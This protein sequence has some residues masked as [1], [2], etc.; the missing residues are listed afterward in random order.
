MQDIIERLRQHEPFFD[1]W[2]L[3]DEKPLGEGN[4][5][6]VYCIND[7]SVDA[8]LKVIALPKDEEQ[9]KRL[10]ETYGNAEYVE[11]MID[12]EYQF[13]VQEI[14]IMRKLKGL[15]NIVCF[16]DS[17]IY[18]REDVHGWDIIIRMERLI[19]LT[20]EHK[21]S[22]KRDQILKMWTDLVT[23]LF[24][25][26]RSGI[27]HL[28]IKPD[29][30]FY[31]GASMNL[32]K[33]GD[34]GVSIRTEN[35]KVKE[36]IMQGSPAYMS[37]EI[38]NG[39][40]GDIRSDIYS[41]AIVIY[42]LLNN[43][44]LPFM[45]RG[46]QS[47]GLDAAIRRRCTPGQEIP[48]IKSLDSG[49][50][51]ILMRCLKYNPSDRYQTVGDLHKDLQQYMVG[52]KPKR[53][54]LLKLLLGIGAG[55]VAG[56]VLFL[57]MQPAS[58][59]PLSFEGS[60]SMVD[61]G[62]RTIRINGQ[63]EM[64]F[65]L[66]I[67]GSAKTQVVFRIVDRASGSVRVERPYT[68]D[69]NG[70][71]TVWS[72]DQ[73]SLEDG[74]YG[75][76]AWYAD[77]TDNQET[78][79]AIVDRV[80]PSAPT[81]VNDLPYAGA[82]NW[83]LTVSA[84]SGATVCLLVNGAEVEAHTVDE[85]GVTV[86]TR[87]YTSEEEYA[88]VTR[89]AVG[90]ESEAVSFSTVQ[91]DVF[92]GISQIDED[93]DELILQAEAGA[94][95]ALSVNGEPIDVRQ[96]RYAGGTEYVYQPEFGFAAGDA[97]V[98]TVTDA[99]GLQ[100]QAEC[101][102]AE[103]SRTKITVEVSNLDDQGRATD[104]DLELHGTA[105]SG[106]VVQLTW[107]GRRVG[108]EI[109]LMEEEF[110][111]YLSMEDVGVTSDGAMGEVAVVYRHGAASR[112]SDPI[113]VNW[114]PGAEERPATVDYRAVDI[115]VIPEIETNEDN[116]W[117]ITGQT[118]REAEINLF[119]GTRSE[120]MEY[121][122]TRDGEQV[123]AGV[124]TLSSTAGAATLDTDLTGL[125]DGQYRL[126][127]TYQNSPQTGEWHQSFIV[128]RTPPELALDGETPY[129]NVYWTMDVALEPGARLT[130]RD[131]D[132]AEVWSET[133]GEEGGVTLR[134]TFE[135]DVNYSLTA[136]DPYGNTSVP[137]RIRAEEK[138][139]L[140]SLQDIREDSEA[141][142]MT[143]DPDVETFVI[144]LNGETLDLESMTM[145]EQDA[146]GTTYSWQPPSG[147]FE[148]GDT[149]TL[150][151]RDK[152]GL[153]AFDEKAVQE[154]NWAQ[155]A[156]TVD[157]VFEADNAVYAR[158]MQLSLS[159]Q[160]DATVE[161]MW[162]G[163]VIGEPILSEG[164]AQ[165][166]L[167]LEDVGLP[168][169]GGTG[170]LSAR[171]GSGYAESRAFK[172][173]EVTWTPDDSVKLHVEPVREDSEVMSI[174]TDADAT[175]EITRIV[176]G[177]RMEP[178]VLETEDG[179]EEWSPESGRFF[180]DE[181]YEVRVV[182]HIGNEQ[183]VRLVVTESTRRPVTL[184]VD[185]R[186]DWAANGVEPYY[187]DVE[188]VIEPTIIVTGSGEPGQRLNL[189]WKDGLVA[190]CLVSADGSYSGAIQAQDLV[191]GEGTLRVEYADGRTPSL[192]QTVDVMWTPDDGVALNDEDDALQL[193]WGG[194]MTV[195]TDPDARV[196]IEME[197]VA[198]DLGH[199]DADGTLVWT[200]EINY[201]IGTSYVVRVTDIFGHTRQSD[202]MQ[203]EEIKRRE[204]QASIDNLIESS[205]GAPGVTDTT[206]A[207]SGTAEPD[208]MLS[209]DI[210]G[211]AFEAK[212][213][214]AGTF[215][216]SIPSA[217]D[218]LSGDEVNLTIAYADGASASNTVRISPFTWD[219]SVA[220][221]HNLPVTE[222][223]QSLVV[224]AAEPVTAELYYRAANGGDWIMVGTL[225]AGEPQDLSWPLNDGSYPWTRG[226][227]GMLKIVDRWGNSDS[228]TFTVGKTA[229][230]EIR[231]EI[232][233]EAGR[234]L[235]G[236]PVV[237]AD[238][239]TVS[240]VGEPGQTVEAM[241]Y[242][243]AGLLATKETTVNE[244]SEYSVPFTAEELGNRYDDKAQYRVVVGYPW[245]KT[246]VNVVTSEVCWDYVGPDVRIA[247][248][249]A[250]DVSWRTIQ[251]STEQGARVAIAIG[252]ATLEVVATDGTFEFKR[253][254]LLK[255][256]DDIVGKTMTVVAYDEAGNPG[257]PWSITF[258]QIGYPGALTIV[259]QKE[260]GS[261]SGKLRIEGWFAGFDKLDAQILLVSGSGKQLG[262]VRPSY[263]DMT[264]EEKTQNLGDRAAGYGQ[265]CYAFDAEYDLT[266]IPAG[267][268]KLVLMHSDFITEE[269]VS[270]VLFD[271]VKNSAESNTLVVEE[272]VAMNVD[273]VAR[274]WPADGIVMTGWICQSADAA[275][276]STISSVR[277]DSLSGA[278]DSV[279]IFFEFE[280]DTSDN[281][282]AVLSKRS[283]AFVDRDISTL[284]PGILP[285]VKSLSAPTNRKA[286]FILNLGA[287][288]QPLPDG[289]YN[290]TI[291]AY[292]GED[293]KP[294]MIG[295]IRLTIDGSAPRMSASELDA[296]MTEWKPIEVVEPQEGENAE[297]E[298]LTEN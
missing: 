114:Q 179:D 227:R 286:G 69:E 272:D 238:T 99:Y 88:L 96:L 145:L 253:N 249:A 92:A 296:L 242:S 183:N 117:L 174:E 251:G 112:A 124:I 1:I 133:A 83:P 57:L 193:Y 265:Y 154:A 105:E 128:D 248:E 290:L 72:T 297:G 78:Y 158:E 51:R 101:V 257:V 58:R 15:S 64:P 175:I 150:E 113:R 41:L 263:R 233:T 200:P 4:S 136:T 70:E 163:A 36:G 140:A 229:L 48:P 186:F 282:Q 288:E 245:E 266:N 59:G 218:V 139:V 202:R 143:V 226:D 260:N 53:G 170:T 27:V 177:T 215:I 125:E 49:L 228:Q 210:N 3:K 90:N 181:I 28:D 207:L 281:P 14:E 280:N 33:L 118:D 9:L 35:G 157:N 76:V 55:G 31:T 223:T 148:K 160:P 94:G 270:E 37:P 67:K 132:G 283:Y 32:Y 214:V 130:L 137:V 217:I 56:V 6:I 38:F 224:S 22:M 119:N 89:D 21:K 289:E 216:L 104:Q 259:N 134:Y 50:S 129:A 279:T 85:G 7:G 147:K 246:R 80:A 54:K 44:C 277:L 291:N 84:E 86:F 268:C 162:N 169:T 264:D 240:G 209:V 135:A 40:G 167:S 52:G 2:W 102:V 192:F 271:V 138:T 235:N 43:N 258:E 211:T 25:C 39:Q 126:A 13:A 74:R 269:Q 189:F 198:F 159:G 146:F 10:Y 93:A 275:D 274:H 254:E 100:G 66:K 149:Y 161:L 231:G 185:N 142:L 191:I 24:Y 121:T 187:A 65:E 141:L 247:N 285:A 203:V 18:R 178:V 267:N 221:E 108:D 205:D 176:D 8:A 155:I 241:L 116:V 81:I 204:I 250:V 220:Y 222:D 62:N 243:E 213:S 255:L 262:T 144:Y 115:M 287:L 75:F 79:E 16:E 194:A 34:F 225:D 60:E 244:H 12:R 47:G 110:T 239:L 219:W 172:G 30:I 152:Y 196:E 19:Q 29:N 208:T 23:G 68:L 298:P 234:R 17:K 61:A 73:L 109:Q 184:I 122:L 63:A 156:L 232:E 106:A 292:G 131:A 295:P 173:V 230:K 46:S 212:V 237:A 5:G 45:N 11:A 206:L 107:N 236:L 261:V 294:L 82:A 20:D 123:E 276:T 188:T 278:V 87:T 166:S 256:T 103:S 71:Q 293:Y 201:D 168:E 180:K 127:L 273:P 195:H 91:K 252:D 26:E 98:V 284:G 153:T 111:A 182:D 190:E 95:I 151:V 199:A 42:E 120:P 165:L 77:Q 197:G 97:Y 171:Y 164:A